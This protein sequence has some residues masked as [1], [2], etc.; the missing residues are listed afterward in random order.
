VPSCTQ[1]DRFYYKEQKLS[2]TK[3]EDVCK[4]AQ[5]FVR[6]GLPFVFH[7][8]GGALNRDVLAELIQALEETAKKKEKH[9]VLSF[10]RAQAVLCVQFTA[11]LPAV[12]SEEEDANEGERYA[13]DE[14]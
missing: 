9:A 7:W 1:K 14:G 10:N 11:E 3:V 4:R 8:R 5:M 2:F 13:P 12:V 6:K